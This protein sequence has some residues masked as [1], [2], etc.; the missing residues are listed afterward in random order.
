MLLSLDK[1]RIAIESRIFVPPTKRNVKA[2][3]ANSTGGRSRR[4]EVR[5]TSNDI[6]RRSATPEPKAKSFVNT[7]SSSRGNGNTEAKVRADGKPSV[8]VEIPA[9]LTPAFSATLP[10][11][12]LACIALVSRF[13]GEYRLVFTEFPFFATG[14]SS[15]Q[16]CN[17]R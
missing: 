1:I 13:F 10:T 8:L 3:E 16:W 4:T 14:F 12:E 9:L 17:R 7:K 15:P 6:H 5:W 2:M 11:V